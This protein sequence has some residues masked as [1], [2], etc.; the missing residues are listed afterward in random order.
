M[1]QAT[2]SL[3]VKADFNPFLLGQS[4]FD[5]LLKHLNV[6]LARLTLSAQTKKGLIVL[7]ASRV[8]KVAEDTRV[9]I[10][11]VRV[12]QI[13]QVAGRLDAV[14]RTELLVLVF[15]VLLVLL[16]LLDIAA[17]LADPMNEV[18]VVSHDLQ[19]VSLVDLALNLE[20]LLKGVHGVF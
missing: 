5:V 2:C 17:H 7:A 6:V 13:L 16:Q 9:F 19:I 20:A 3:L 11:P 14:L 18:H 12:F 4:F 8:A 10:E 1:K 15:F